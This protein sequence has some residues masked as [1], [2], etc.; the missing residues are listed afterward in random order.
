[1]QHPDFDVNGWI[2]REMG[3][4]MDSEENRRRYDESERILDS[5]GR[6]LDESRRAREERSRREPGETQ[7]A[8]GE[9]GAW[10]EWYIEHSNCGGTWVY[11][12]DPC[13]PRVV[14]SCTMG[15]GGSA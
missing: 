15:M 7:P 2:R 3:R 14:C 9:H 5:M 11:V 8:I 1:M 13:N 12:K 10:Q 6:E 4:L